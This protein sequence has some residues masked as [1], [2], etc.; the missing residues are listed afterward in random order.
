MIK[1]LFRE[2]ALTAMVMLLVSV[3]GFLAL[4]RALRPDWFGLVGFA[5]VLRTDPDRLLGRDLPAIWNASPPDAPQRTLRDLRD[6]RREDPAASARLAARGTAALPTVLAQFPSLSPAQQRRV[7]LALARVEAGI[8]AADPPPS[9]GPTGDLG[10]ARQYW[11]RYDAAHG[12]DFRDRYA[13]R[14][15][16]RLLGGLSANAGERVARLGSYGLPALV[17]AMSDARDPAAQARVVNALADL[18][19]VPVRV[20]PSPDP[21]EVR[22][23]VEAWRAWWFAHHAEYTTLGSWQRS[24]AR[25][26]ETRY[27]QWLSR[28]LRGR[29]G[30]CAVTRRSIAAELRERIAVSSLAA[31]LG[32]L[33]GVGIAIAFGGGDVLRRRPLRARVLDLLGAVIPGLIALLAGWVALLRVLNPDA[34]VG[35]ILGELLD[36]NGATRFIAAS[37]ACAALPGAAL[38]QPRSSAFLDA[39]RVEAEAWTLRGQSPSLRRALRHA[40]RIA[41]ASLLCPLA[42]AAPMV[43][44]ASLIVETALRLQGM[45]SLTAHA[46]AAADGPWLLIA[47]ITVVP[48]ILGR[49]WASLALVWLLGTRPD[50]RV[51]RFRGVSLPPPQLG[52]DRLSVP[53][54]A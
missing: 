42:L 11:E 7:L 44:T 51:R 35:S 18:T 6:L 37:V 24:L 9:P 47:V 26:V 31:G 52:E 23:A 17:R 45:G 2:A 43:L 54:P 5:A 22:Y 39:V 29:L 3:G 13:E 48:V 21:A 27:G 34:P 46:V 36:R 53:P 33:L 16:A 50:G 8:N 32:G 49:R 28:S 14:Q 25:A 41:A 15:A 20:R 38:M 30:V 4:D 10:P 19:G 12:L 1:V 40:A